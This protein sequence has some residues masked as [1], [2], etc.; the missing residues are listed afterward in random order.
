MSTI[1]GDPKN[2]YG[3]RGR[4]ERIIKERKRKDGREGM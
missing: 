1:R 2:T 3:R 4:K